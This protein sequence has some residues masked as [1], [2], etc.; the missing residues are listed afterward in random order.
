MGIFQTLRQHDISGRIG[1][2]RSVVI[3]AAPGVSSPVAD[4][5]CAASARLTGAV[6]AVLDATANCARMGYGRFDEAER[7]VRAGVD[8]RRE[9]G[10]RQGLLIVDNRGWA[11]ALPAEF[12]ETD[13]P[14]GTSAPNAIELTPSQVVVL[15]AELPSPRRAK[16]EKT[17][18]AAKPASVPTVGAQPLEPAV[19]EQVKRELQIA[20][21]QPFDLAR[22]VLV[23]NALV[24]FVELEMK[25]WK[26]EGRQVKLPADRLPILSTGDR[27]LKQ[28]IKSSLNMLDQIPEGSLRGLRA[29][30]E[31]LRKAFCRPVGA[32][33]S[34]VLVSSQPLLEEKIK[35]IQNKLDA[36]KAALTAQIQTALDKVVEGLVPELAR[37]V[38]AD[39]PNAFLG[40]YGQTEDGARDYV[41]VELARVFPTAQEIVSDMSLRLTFKDV[42]YSVLKDQAFKDKVL[43]SFSRTALPRELLTEYDAAKGRAVTGVGA[44]ERF[45]HE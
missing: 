37:A 10:L 27:D 30:V 9:A 23:Y 19:I 28:R 8:V 1:E 26:L 40:R 29:E 21:P 12:L 15:R 43:T 34:V 24:R 33:G 38:L 6:I 4:A 36:E 45:T 11:F 17:S 31:E 5:L 14:E 39:P 44:R 7:L 20:P 25:G 41:R 2:A 42:T 16:D 13:A 22:Q 18:E 35:A 3:Y 32:I